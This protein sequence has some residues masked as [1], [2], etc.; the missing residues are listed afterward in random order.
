MLHL[1]NNDLSAAFTVLA[2]MLDD[3]PEDPLLLGI[4][5]RLYEAVG[6][7]ALANELRRELDELEL[8]VGA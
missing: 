7:T 4:A 6:G 5:V 1:K 2:G 8:E 3:N